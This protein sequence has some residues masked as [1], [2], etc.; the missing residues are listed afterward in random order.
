M[1]LDLAVP[2]V[3]KQV[4]KDKGARMFIAE[5]IEIEKKM[6]TIQMFNNRPLV[7]QIML[8]PYNGMKVH[9]KA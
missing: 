9:K 8:H 6:K 2:L 4:G 1:F 5:L 3:L 7:K